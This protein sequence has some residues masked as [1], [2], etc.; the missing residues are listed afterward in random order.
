[1]GRRSAE[2]AEGS[3]KP[4]ALRRVERAARKAALSRQQLDEAIREA[5]AEGQSTRKIAEA[6]K[7]SHTQV[8]RTIH[9]DQA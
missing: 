1:M 2:D 4:S 6:A 3:V 7:V 8:Q 9:R 5:H